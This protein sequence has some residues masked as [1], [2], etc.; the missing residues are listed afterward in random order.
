MS[1]DGSEVKKVVPLDAYFW[2][3]WKGPVVRIYNTTRAELPE[4]SRLQTFLTSLAAVGHFTN[5]VIEGIGGNIAKTTLYIGVIG[6]PAAGKTTV[7]YHVF[8]KLVKRG[9]NAKIVGTRTSPEGLARVLAETQ[10]AIHIADEVHQ[11]FRGKRRESYVGEVLDLWK[12]LYY[13]VPVSFARRSR[14]RTIDIPEDAKLTVIW[15]TTY[16]DFETVTSV[17]DRALMRRF[18]VVAVDRIVDPWRRGEVMEEEWDRIAGELMFLSEFEW[19][20]KHSIEPEVVDLRNSIVAELGADPE[21][22][23]ILSEQSIRIATILALDRIVAV[24]EKMISRKYVYTSSSPPST[25]NLLVEWFQ[26]LLI[27]DELTSSQLVDAVEI[28]EGGTPGEREPG[29]RV[30][31]RQSGNASDDR[32][33]EYQ[34]FNLS[35]TVE[36]D[37]STLSTICRNVVQSLVSS[38]STELEKFSANLVRLLANYTIPIPRVE[39]NRGNIVTVYVPPHYL[40]LALGIVATSIVSSSFVRQWIGMDERWAY[41]LR[42]LGDFVERGWTVV[43]MRDLAR[44]M[45]KFGGYRE[46]LDYV[47]KAVAVGVLVIEADEEGERDVSKARF[48]INLD[49]LFMG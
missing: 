28:V 37:V 12:T 19:V 1:G 16:D 18:M 24:L 5:A 39:L 35:K 29:N 8:R 32:G 21:L 45:K 4:A 10:S 3:P 48:R 31:L 47:K 46:L 22:M 40:V 44:Y 23:Q 7:P 30:P 33:E 17:I 20:V 49:S 2:I 43:T 36:V 15:T 11:L 14:K 41:F 42:R 34:T 26:Q 6:V 9:L 25:R 27:S 38:M 13:R